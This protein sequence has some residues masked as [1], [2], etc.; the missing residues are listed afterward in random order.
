MYL[1]LPVKELPLVVCVLN[2]KDI[3]YS[4]LNQDQI[5]NHFEGITSLTTKRGLCDL[6]RSVHLTV[7][8]DF[9]E[10]A[11]R[12]YNLGDPMHRDEFIDDFRM[13][14]A[15]NILKWYVL[16]STRSSFTDL[17][18]GSS[19]FILHDQQCKQFSDNRGV[20]INMLY[21]ALTACLWFI[22][23]KKYGEWP[24]VDI[25]KYFK[26][27]DVCL[28]ESQWCCLLDYSYVIAEHQ[29]SHNLSDIYECISL[30][31]NFIKYV[32]KSRID[33]DVP[34]D[35]FL[36]KVKSIISCFARIHKQFSA[37]DGFRNIWVMK[38]PDSSCGIG[39]H[40]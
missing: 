30:R 32:D 5:C 23:V 35:P 6:L 24:G 22:R 39:K 12:C 19:R 27:K 29:H 7:P 40:Y 18:Q 9:N 4:D 34:F 17:S 36:F 20:D 25:S 16:H 10:L 31:E 15:V 33:K 26:D 37:V 21:C 11:P 2:E 13:V 1:R 8:E 38:A 14:A 3:N 28:E